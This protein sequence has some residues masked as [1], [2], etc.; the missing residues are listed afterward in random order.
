[1]NTKTLKQKGITLHHVCGLVPRDF[2][3]ESYHS[4]DHAEV[5]VHVSGEMELFIENNVYFHSGNEIRVYAPATENGSGL[6]EIVTEILAGLKKAD[7]QKIITDT[8]A[9]PIAFDPDMNAI[10]RTVHF[11]LEFCLCEE[12]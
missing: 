1:M 9:S 3:C 2:W 6:S 11:S 8:S 4:H 5:F 10:Y 7:S 12:V